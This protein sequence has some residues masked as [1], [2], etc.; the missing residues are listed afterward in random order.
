MSSNMNSRSITDY[1]LKLEKDLVE[2]KNKG[3]ATPKSLVPRL[4]NSRR[5]LLVLKFE[6]F[7]MSSAKLISIKAP[8]INSR[9]R[10]PN[11][12][13]RLNSSR[14]CTPKPKMKRLMLSVHSLISSTRPTACLNPATRTRLLGFVVNPHTAKLVQTV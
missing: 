7:L 1:I 6:G 13:P 11:L 2:T 8:S 10:T 14:S 12:A 9:R 5:I 4:S 3:I